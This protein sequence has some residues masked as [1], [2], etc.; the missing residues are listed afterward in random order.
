M[1]SEQNGVSSMRKRSITKA[2]YD[3]DLKRLLES[4]GILDKVVEGVMICPVCGCRVNLDNLGTI[5]SD[6]NDIVVS[7]DDTKCVRAVT[8]G[9]VTTQSG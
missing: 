1:K 8:S 6:G 5:F 9:E 7:C 4:L 2:V 3:R